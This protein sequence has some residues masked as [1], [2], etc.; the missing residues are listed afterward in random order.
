[1]RSRDR[2]ALARLKR[3]EPLALPQN[4]ARAFEQ[5]EQLEHNHP[6]SRHL[7]YGGIIRPARHGDT[8]QESK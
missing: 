2:F 3:I 8:R 7:A 1:M 4:L 6:D 5:V